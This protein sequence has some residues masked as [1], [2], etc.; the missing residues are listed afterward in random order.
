MRF[1]FD[2]ETF[3]N[4]E[5]VILVLLDYSKAFDCDNYDLI[6]AKPKALGFQ[7]SALQML[8]SYLYCRQQKIKIEND[9]SNRC[10]LL[11]GIPPRIYPGSF[12][13]YGS[14]E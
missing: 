8:S 13:I 1:I 12:I 5:V 6:L 4:G 14:V 3:D 7:E 11:N 9:V 2:F 10:K